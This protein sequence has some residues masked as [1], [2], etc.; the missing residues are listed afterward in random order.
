MKTKLKIFIDTEPMSPREWD[1]IGTMVCWHRRYNLGD[2]QPCV[3]P[4]VYELPDDEGRVFSLPLYL[5]DH[6]GITMRTSPFRSQWDSGK[7]GFI[8]VTEERMKKE[9]SATEDLEEKALKLLN[10]EV[11]TYD[12]YLRGDVWG[13][14][15]IKLCEHCGSEEDVVDSCYGFF[16]DSL[17]DTGL[18]ESIRDFGDFTKKQIEE[19][20][21]KRLED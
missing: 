2:E 4:S 6:S 19:A 21:D 8:Y 16:G 18:L 1:N 20:W 7:V 14:Q 10:G 5:Y 15:I 12:T 3:S 11:K 13:F 17:E 9:F